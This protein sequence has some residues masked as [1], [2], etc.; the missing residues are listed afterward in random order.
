M[1]DALCLVTSD[2]SNKTWGRNTVCRQE[3]FEDIKRNFK[4]KG[5]TW[6]PNSIQMKERTDGRERYTCDI[7]WCLTVHC[8]TEQCFSVY[9][10]AEPF[11][12]YIGQTYLLKSN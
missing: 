5:C 10:L 11:T 3:E 6:G 7:W 1:S 12:C 2:E 9:F 4:K 8:G